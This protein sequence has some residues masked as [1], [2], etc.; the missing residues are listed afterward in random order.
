[1]K[2]WNIEIYLF[3][4]NFD[5]LIRL[6]LSIRK[7]FVFY[8]FIIVIPL[9]IVHFVVNGRRLSTMITMSAE[10]AKQNRFRIFRFVVAMF[11]KF[12]LADRYFGSLRCWNW[13]FLSWI[14][15]ILIV[16]V[17]WSFGF[18]NWLDVQFGCRCLVRFKCIRFYGFFCWSQ[19]TQWPKWQWFDAIWYY[20]D[21]LIHLECRERIRL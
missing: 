14:F 18:N 3:F 2:D 17:C 11:R 10:F 16:G 6:Q 20:I 7:F 9:K 1:M 15:V 5:L 8:R 4:W 21:D 19:R 12:F 13:R